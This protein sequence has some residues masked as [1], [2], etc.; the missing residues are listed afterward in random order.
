MNIREANEKIRDERNYVAVYDELIEYLRK[1][2]SGELEI[3]VDTDDEVV[4]EV[5][6]DSVIGMLE[7]LRSEHEEKI[8]SIEGME[9]GSG[10]RKRSKRSGSGL[11]LG[12]GGSSRP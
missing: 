6:V 10:K 11:S 12:V 8:Q 9:I 7:E 3:P 4:G 1:V 5:Y 2:E